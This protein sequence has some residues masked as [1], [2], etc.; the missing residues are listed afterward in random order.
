R[1]RPRS[2]PG[3]DGGPTRGRSPVPSSG[4]TRKVQATD[5][6]SGTARSP[7]LFARVEGRGLRAAP[8]LQ[9]EVDQPPGEL[10]H[11]VGEQVPGQAMVAVDVV[12][13][14]VPV[15]EPGRA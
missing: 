4:L 8:A 3:H 7:V 2:G 13:E 12:L 10:R 6:G 11:G 15:A 1:R 14:A 9:P 5:G